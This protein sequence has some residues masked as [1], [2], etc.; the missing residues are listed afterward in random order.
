M[1]L[2]VPLAA[3]YAQS[4][5]SGFA[6]GAVALGV[7]PQNPSDGPGALYLGANAEF[8]GQPLSASI[9]AEQAAVN[10]A[11]LCGEPG[12]QMLAVSAA[13]CGLCRQFLREIAA[14]APG[15]RLICKKNP[16]PLDSARTARLLDELLPDAFGP[17]DLGMKGGLML[18]QDHGLV[19]RRAGVLTTAAL[20]AA[21]A[22]YA[23]YTGCFAGIAV[24][25]D[26]GEIVCGRYAE[27]A[28]FNPS[29][30]AIQSALSLMQL[31]LET[32]AP[33][34]IREAVL[35]ER[36]GKPAAQLEATRSLL[37]AAAPH[38]RLTHHRARDPATRQLRPTKL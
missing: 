5:V 3:A 34:R 37:T 26:S 27:N 24:R 6:V 30:L 10:N 17:S 21:N 23:P 35:V 12:L 22:S 1:V 33:K 32:G 9:H 31:Q 20:G 28:A 15:L 18:P 38:A 19:L 16:D 4:P 14:G 29:L 7:S 36:P 11:W 2:I 13:P 8:A 25:T